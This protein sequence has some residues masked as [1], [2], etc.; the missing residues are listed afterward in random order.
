[1]SIFGKSKFAINAWQWYLNSMTTEE[2]DAKFN[3]YTKSVRIVTRSFEDGSSTPK[4]FSQKK[5]IENAK[6]VAKELNRIDAARSR[7]AN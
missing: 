6:K 4:H 3:K 5:F 2:I 1:L 7:E